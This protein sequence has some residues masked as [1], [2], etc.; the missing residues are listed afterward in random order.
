MG[1]VPFFMLPTGVRCK[2]SLNSY[3]CY[4]ASQT[5]VCHVSASAIFMMKRLCMCR[6]THCHIFTRGKKN[7]TTAFWSKSETSNWN[8]SLFKQ[9]QHLMETFLYERKLQQRI[10]RQAGSKPFVLRKILIVNI[11][12]EQKVNFTQHQ[13]TVEPQKLKK[14]RC[15]LSDT[16]QRLTLLDGCEDKSRV[17]LI[18]ASGRTSTDC[19]TAWWRNRKCS[20]LWK[21][22]KKKPKSTI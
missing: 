20:Q 17:Q 21:E 22:Q 6:H 9:N 13:E 4:K 7:R 15:V 18:S 10:Q 3:C 11:L 12:R 8:W 2:A 1:K 14:I 5:S 19:S 16:C